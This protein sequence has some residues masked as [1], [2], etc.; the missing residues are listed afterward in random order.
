MQVTI[1]RAPTGDRGPPE[2]ITVDILTVEQLGPKMSLLPNG[3][4]LCRDVPIARVGWMIYG[5]GE[6]PISPG[7]SGVA[8]VERTADELF[9]EATIGSF[10]AAAVVDGHPTNANGEVIDVD[11][12]NWKQLAKG[13]SVGNVRRGTGDQADVLLSDLIISDEKLIKDVRAGKREVSAGYDADYKRTGPGMGRQTNIIGNHIALVEKGRCGPRCAI[14][15]RAPT[16]TTEGKSM[17]RVPLKTERKTLDPAALEAARAKVADAQAELD[18]IEASAAEDDKDNGVH[19]H[20]HQGSEPDAKGKTGDRLSAI[21]ATVGE[22]A[23]TVKTLVEKI[24]PAVVETPEAK[25]A[26]EAAESATAAAATAEA[27]KKAAAT[28]NE[29]LDPATGKTH[30]SAALAT[31]YAKVLQ[32]AEIL[33]PGFRMPTFDAALPRAKT[34]DNMCAARRRCLD[35]AYATTDGKTLVDSIHGSSGD[36]DISKLD[37]KEAALLFNAAVSV[38]GAQNN[39]AATGDGKM[40][41]Q[42]GEEVK[43]PRTNADLNKLHETFWAQQQ[44]AA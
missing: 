37:C 42:T 43:K 12:H 17:K 39:R 35:M 33:V 3:S 23:T 34:V 11:T 5:P 44:S 38:K 1:K 21:E 28:G 2:D 8:Y 26:R 19:V 4:L 15:D 18:E 25:A 22:L 24:A 31:G 9:S 41:A 10:M 14:G 13:F 30:D 40:G 20:I 36:L 16:S 27:L 32:Q 7:P 6:V 29:D